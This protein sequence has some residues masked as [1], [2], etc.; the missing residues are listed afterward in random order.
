[1][2]PISRPSSSPRAGRPGRALIA[3]AAAAALVAGAGAGT[4]AG[5]ADGCTYTEFP[6]EYVCA[7]VT[8]KKLHVEKVEVVRGKLPAGVID[9]YHGEANVYTPDGRHLVFR[10]S[11]RTGKR[12]AR[13]HVTIRIGRSFPDGSKIC[14]AFFERGSWIDSACFRIHD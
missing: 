13:A 10:S 3:A 12:Y 14:G 5:S 8:G 7:S 11:L 2:S 6:H 1:M 4:A 9:D